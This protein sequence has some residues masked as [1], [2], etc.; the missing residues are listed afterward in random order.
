MILENPRKQVHQKN[1]L[2]TELH[3]GKA[4]IEDNDPMRHLQNLF[5]NT[6]KSVLLIL[7]ANLGK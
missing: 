3:F 7:T 4:E 1:Y 6:R 2:H 5:I